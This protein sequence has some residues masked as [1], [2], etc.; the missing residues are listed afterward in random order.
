MRSMPSSH[1]ALAR[2]Q[3][4]TPTLVIAPVDYIG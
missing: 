3:E 1:S 2:P 4:P